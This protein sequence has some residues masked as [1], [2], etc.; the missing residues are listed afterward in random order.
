M[1]KNLRLKT[2]VI[3]ATLLVFMW[4]IFLGTNPKASVDAMRKASAER[5]VGAGVL[6]GI[7][8]NIHLGLDL[9]GGLHMILQVMADEAVNSDVQ[10]AVDRLQTEARNKNVRFAQI[11]T[12]PDRADRIVINGVASEQGSALRDMVS[13]Q[14][15]EYDYSSGQD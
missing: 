14:F 2:I 11:A 8:E 5:G 3:F 9:K 4:G 10:R 6:A 13:E 7:Q 12:A 1:N 15:P